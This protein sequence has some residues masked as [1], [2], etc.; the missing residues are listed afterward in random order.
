MANSVPAAAVIQR[1]Q[2]LLGF[3]GR[4]GAQADS[5]VGR[6]IPGLNPGAAFETTSLETWRGKRNSWWSSEMRRYQEEHQR[7]RQLTGQ[8]LTLRLESVGS[9]RD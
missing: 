7:R 4:K 2:A 1:L 8:D 5:C 6:E 9:K 3:T